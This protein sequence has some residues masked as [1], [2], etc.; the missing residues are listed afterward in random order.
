MSCWIERQKETIVAILGFSAENLLYDIQ[1]NAYIAGSLLEGPENAHKRT[2]IQD[3]CNEGN[4]DRVSRVL[5]K[6]MAKVKEELY[7]FT[8]GK[9]D[10][11]ILQNRL[12]HKPA[13]GIVLHLPSDF[14]QTTLNLLE[15]EIHEFMVCSVLSDWLNHIAP[16]NGVIWA[17]KSDSAWEEICRLKNRRIGKIRRRLHPF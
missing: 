9:I 5:D 14:S 10:H 15:K 7:P 13:Y 1:N 16:E 12:V 4:I 11:A 6:S 2:L 17:T 3:L 8:K